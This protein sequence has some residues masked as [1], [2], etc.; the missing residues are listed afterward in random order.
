MCGCADA[1]GASGHEDA[2]YRVMAAMGTICQGA[3]AYSALAKELGVPAVAAG[4]ASK[5]S[6][7]KVRECAQQLGAACM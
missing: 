3:P 5:S 7:Q 6:S 4:I 1:A 2:V